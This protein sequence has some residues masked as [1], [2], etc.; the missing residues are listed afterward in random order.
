VFGYE[1]SAY[2]KDIRDLVGIEFVETYTGARYVRLTNSDFGDVIGITVAL[3]HHALGPVNL[4]LDYTWQEARG[5]SSDPLER[6]NRAA[7]GEDPRPRVIP[8][9]WDQRHTLNMTLALAKPDAYIVSAVL[10]AVTGQPYTPS[11]ETAFGFG[12]D[13]N[14][15]RKPS[16]AL[17]D[18]RAERSFR[19]GGLNGGLYARVFNVFD[20]R[21]FNGFVFDTT[22]SP[23]YPRSVTSADYV[24]LQDPTRYYGPR[25][26]ELGLILGSQ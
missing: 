9:D 2:Y 4:A 21:F 8:F 1:V 6:A 16:G 18:L 5:N 14:S 22:G 17:V 7:G 25:R 26:V 24:Q 23:Y 19:T 10:R 3:D 20:A 15:G 13:A 12:L 11:F